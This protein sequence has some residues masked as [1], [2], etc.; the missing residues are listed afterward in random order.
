MSNDDH[1]VR[2]SEEEGASDKAA[3]FP[4]VGIGTSAG[5]VHALQMFFERLP[6]EVDALSLLSC[7][8]I[9]RAKANFPTF[10][11]LGHGCR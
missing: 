9:L 6:D 2:P 5:G 4:T 8:L 3:G 11:L 1:G 7:I 10:S